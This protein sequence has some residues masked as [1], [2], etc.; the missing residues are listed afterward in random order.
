MTL[1]CGP[2]VVKILVPLMRQPPSARVALVFSSVTA[3]PA[4]GSVMPT[5]MSPSPASSPVR[6]FRFCSGLPYSASTRMAP[7][8]PACTTS[9]LRG[10]TDATVSMAMTA[11][12]SEP[13]T[14]PS[15]CATVMPSRPCPAILRAM[16]HG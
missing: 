16:S 10:H 2:C 1:A 11:S 15:S 6:Y 13:P 14:P 7:K 5:E 12:I 3:E 9:A 4:S 8:L